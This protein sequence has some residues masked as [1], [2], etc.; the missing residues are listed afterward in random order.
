MD[1]KAQ[2]LDRASSARTDP[3]KRVVRVRTDIQVVIVH[4]HAWLWEPTGM[5]TGTPPA[6]MHGVFLGRVDIERGIVRVATAQSWV[7]V[8]CCFALPAHKN[9]M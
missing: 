9:K 2:R 3:L 4:F 8:L 6:G 7:S 5:V 1:E